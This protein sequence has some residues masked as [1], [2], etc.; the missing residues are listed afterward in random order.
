[1]ILSDS[2]I[3]LQ[4]DTA[5]TARTQSD[6]FAAHPCLDPSIQA[7]YLHRGFWIYGMRQSY[8]YEAAAADLCSDP[9]VNRALPIY[10]SIGGLSEFRVSDLIDIQFDLVLS[11]ESA[12][13]LLAAHGL[14]F[15]DSSDYKHNL[16]ECALDDTIKISALAIG[17]AIH[18]SPGV[19]W[20]CAR[21]YVTPVLM[22]VPTDPYYGYQ[23]YLKNTGQNW[24]TRGIDIN[25]ESAWS[26][27]LTDSSLKVAVIDD[28]VTGHHEWGGKLRLLQGYD[29]AGDCLTCYDSLPPD[30]DPKPGTDRN[31]GMACTG[32]LAA[33]HDGMGIA[34]VFGSCLELIPKIEF[35]VGSSRLARSPHL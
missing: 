31:H 22:G 3:G 23:Y 18:M 6:F 4:F 7:T 32:I 35:W 15:V 26:I 8:G 20:A 1:M 34:G 21:Q 5:Q 19:T 2:K 13:E 16:W 24:G 14:R 10:T 30:D 28:G 9:T 29:F 12:L 11:R 25:V 27:S 17:N 33:S